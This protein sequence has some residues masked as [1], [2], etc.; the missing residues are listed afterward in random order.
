[1]L[2]FQPDT[3]NRLYVT[4]FD[5]DRNAAA[6]AGPLTF[7][8][9]A[10][11]SDFPTWS[12]LAS[13][14][15][16]ME[17]GYTLFI[18]SN[19]SA[20]KNYATIMNGSG[21]VIWYCPV[22]TTDGDV[23]QLD[24]GDLFIQQ[25]LPLN[26]FLEMNLL[27]ETVKTWKA[28][29]G[30]PIDQHDGFLTDHGTIL[31]LSN[32]G[33][34]VS[35]FPSSSTVSNPP[36]GTVTVAD[37]PIV[38]ISTT[39]SLLLNHWSPLDMLDPTRVTYLTTLATNTANSVVTV[40]NEHANALLEDTNDNNSIIV[41]LRN[42]NAVFKFS[43][44]GQLKWILGPHEGWDTN[45]ASYLLTPVGAPFDWNYGQH[46]PWLTP[47][48]TLI[49][50]NDGNLRASPLEPQVPD[51]D[52]YSSACEYAIDETNME[53]SE[54]W[55]SAWQTNQDRLFTP[56]VGKAQPLPQTTNVLVTYGYVTY[57]NGAHPSPYSPAATMARIKE[58]THAA[59]PDVVYDVSF[60]DPTNT[61]STYLGCLIYR[62]WQIPHLY[63]HA[64]EAVA[65][66][67]VT[68]TNQMPVLEFSADPVYSYVIQ[69][70]TNI[71]DWTTLGTAVEQD[72]RGNF[73]FD[74]TTAVGHKVRFY[75]VMTQ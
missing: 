48:G 10:L 3:T 65:D 8:A 67:V 32:V 60:F 33:E 69:A 45:L 19:R 37:N 21:E 38:E 54:V 58:Y 44:E 18:V 66:L 68:R 28:A 49:L 53:V 39:N 27:G 35:N 25:Q 26:N 59:A 72:D 11:P 24:N 64:P 30:Y 50:Y 14:P 63:P 43:R 41:S 56:I 40:D 34:V 1:L 57:V 6:A 9:P 13:E 73:E 70:S 2:V 12:V 16:R 61:S 31:Y 7:M 62:A 17:P 71:V 74:D 20:K 75:R 23:H 29:A 55:N 15:S 46:A 42:Q 36:L 5:E 52:N 4:V 51:Q 22:P 47:W